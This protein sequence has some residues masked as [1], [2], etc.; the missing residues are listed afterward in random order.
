M[1]H[2][3]ILLLTLS[4]F[5]SSVYASIFE[6][7]WSKWD[8]LNLM[9]CEAT[10]HDQE[11]LLNLETAINVLSGAS[12]LETEDYWSKPI[13][14]FRA[15]SRPLEKLKDLNNINLGNFYG[16]LHYLESKAKFLGEDKTL[17]LTAIKVK[18]NMSLVS[19]YYHC[20]QGSCEFRLTCQM[21]PCTTP[22]DAIATPYTR[23]GIK[24]GTENIQLSRCGRSHVCP[25]DICLKPDEGIAKF[26]ACVNNESQ[27]LDCYYSFTEGGRRLSYQILG[28]SDSKRIDWEGNMKEQ[29]SQIA[30][31]IF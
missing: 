19:D 11:T 26:K 13:V 9:L 3:L 28:Q 20:E 4:I 24:L 30:N 1:Y 7:A 8:S 5:S 18:I 29:L 21:G 14:L 22:L 12:P 10:P 15:T 25:E 6:T 27:N 31:E 17:Y 2:L 16:Q 23:V